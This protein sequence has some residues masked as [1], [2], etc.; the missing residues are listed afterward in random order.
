VSGRLVVVGLGPGSPDQ[1]TRAAAEELAAAEVLVGYRAYLDQVPTS[2]ASGR[3]EEFGLGEERERAR[4]AVTAA[5]AG[6][7]VALVS[8]GDPGIYG[9]AS[10]A[11]D[12]AVA[13]GEDAPQLVV[14]PGVTAASAAAAVLGAPLAVDFACLSL[15]DLLVPRADLLGR[16]DALASADIVL[17]LYNPASRSRRE[18]WEAAVAA[19]QRHRPAQTPVASVRRAYRQGQEVELSEVGGMG[20]LAVDMETVVVVGSRQ[21]RRSGTWMYTLREASDA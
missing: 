11:I 18:P 6:A 4:R 17:V 2:L 13:L 7:R 16:V 21:T 10:L 14:L 15:S 12:E 9:M 20:D 8:S 3:R 1:L 19:L 5:A